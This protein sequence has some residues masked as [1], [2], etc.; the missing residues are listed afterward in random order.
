MLRTPLVQINLVVFKNH[1]RLHLAQ[2]GGAKAAGEFVKQ[3]GAIGH[4]LIQ[5]RKVGGR[6]SRRLLRPM[7]ATIQFM[8]WDFLPYR[9]TGASKGRSDRSHAGVSMP[10]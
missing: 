8:S 3:V 1:F 2:A 6:V 4:V 5:M 10:C 7:V 9:Q